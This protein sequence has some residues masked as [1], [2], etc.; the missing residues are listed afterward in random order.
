MAL[1]FS[2]MIFSFLNLLLVFDFGKAHGMEIF[3]YAVYAAMAIFP[4]IIIGSTVSSHFSLGKRRKSSLKDSVHMSKGEHL[5]LNTTPHPFYFAKLAV[6]IAALAALM[7]YMLLASSYLAPITDAGWWWRVLAISGLASVF[8][9]SASADLLPHNSILETVEHAWA[10]FFAFWWSV[11]STAVV[12]AQIELNYPKAFWEKFLGLPSLAMIMFAIILFLMSSM[13]WKIDRYISGK[14]ATTP[15]GTISI[16]LM[17][18]GIAALFPPLWFLFS[19][20]VRE[21]FFYATAMMTLLLWILLSAFLYYRGGIRFIFTNR[22]IIISKRFIGTYLDEHPY[23]DIL[24][25]ELMQGF[26]GRNLSYGDL[27]F[28]VK[29]GNKIV[30]FTVPAVRNPALAKNMVTVLSKNGKKRKNQ[31]APIRKK[32]TIHYTKPY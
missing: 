1:L 31:N 15:L 4:L 7:L 23:D 6:A 27:R 32:R 22:R 14:K 8:V 25:V 20:V 17:A 3:R 19:D 11:S 24:S 5:L 9:Y 13:I 26:F 28:R 18:A 21:T 16:T 10:L 30:K 29:R 12:K 2:A